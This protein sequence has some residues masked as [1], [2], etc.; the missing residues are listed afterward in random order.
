MTRVAGR[1]RETGCSS[2]L[3]A[4]VR[5]TDDQGGVIQDAQVHDSLRGFPCNGT[6][7]VTLAPGRYDLAVHRLVSHEW[8][9]QTLVCEAG[10]DQR[11]EVELT[12]WV[13]PW[14]RGFFCGESHD[15][16]NHLH[17]GPAAVTYCEA[18]GISY[19]DV[20]QSWMT[21]REKDRVITG[22]EIARTLESHST[23]TFHMYF[24][25]E[26]P[27]KRFG[28][29][30]WTNLTP[31]A[32]PFG[33]Y[34]GWHDADY[35]TFCTLPRPSAEVDV[36]A[37]CPSELGEPFNTWHRF[38]QLGAVG[39]SAHPT[40]WWVDNTEQKLLHTNI[41]VDMIYAL[42]AGCPVDAMV[43]MGYDPDQVFYQNLWFSLLNEGYRLPACAETDGNLK[44][45]HHIGQILSH[46]RT[47]DGRYSRIGIAE[48]IKAGRVLMSS[49]PFILFSA[50][51]GRY[52]M[53]DE[54]LLDSP[55]H[56]LEIEAWSDPDPAEFLSMLVVYRNGVPFH[57]EDLRARKPR[58]LRFTLPV[59]EPR[60]RAWYVVKAY[61]SQAPAEERFLD[62]FAYTAL[63]ERE[64]HDEYR[65]LKQVALTN[66]L[67]FI[68]RGW[69]PPP[70]VRSRLHL[71]TEPGARVVVTELGE[72]KQT[73]IADAN[74]RVEAEVSPIAELAL[75]TR[76]SAPIHRSIFLHYRPVS[77]L[78]EYGYTGQWRPHTPS[79][80]AP[81][82]VP[83]RAFRFAELRQALQD[84]HWRLM[85]EAGS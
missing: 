63:C 11:L 15:H 68:P 80:M 40:S 76:T 69:T 46:T 72:K 82:Q 54:I 75:T 42:L 37:H 26:R 59:N 44:G 41:A 24:G 62:V 55:D 50:D 14:K 56:T 9:V 48:G 13:D 84:I 35:V 3:P 19:L 64:L 74:G 17:E 1:I 73:L 23:G 39:V 2:L 6:F 20:C 28:H 38:R 58:H 18:L 43:A 32:D 31:F 49:G 22:H 45:A 61:G 67:Y 29:V 60:D 77:S 34:M 71:E 27:K 10:R 16:L 57:T 52:Q 51:N 66:P 70:P 7:E 33:E 47:L 79:G 4:W 25:G 5:I 12:P 83:W 81:G 21:R 78:V 30:W 8:F 65:F 36:Q 53:G 85:P